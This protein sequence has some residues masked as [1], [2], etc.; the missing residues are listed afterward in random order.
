MRVITSFAL[1]VV[2]VASL[3]SCDSKFIQ[4]PESS[5]KQPSDTDMTK[6]K[7]YEQGAKIQI[8]Y[9]TDIDQIAIEIYQIPLN[10]VS[11]YTSL[12]RN[13]SENPS[14]WLAEYD[15]LGL[16]KGNE[17]SVY[18][19][20]LFKSSQGRVARSDYFNVSS[21]QADE[22]TSASMSSTAT[23]PGLATSASGQHA[24]T[25][26]AGSETDTE[27]NSS[28][29]TIST[30]STTSSTKS[31]SGLS[32]GATAGVTAG[33]II[34]GLLILGGIGLFVWRRFGKGR[35]NVKRTEE[36]QY[37]QH[38][39]YPLETKVELPSDIT[40]HPSEYATSRPGIH[41]AP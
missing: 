4:P 25:M 30:T 37:Q 21:P 32:Q 19:F 38:Q 15:F 35:K 27:H 16:A 17:D 3:A 29:S 20:T 34:G 10:G 14:Y 7:R 11:A 39:F 33:A 41:E 36:A 40:T 5:S 1:I 18:W 13:G 23:G 6:N 12:A 8:E 28:T 24:S 31:G 26:T 9:E 2:G 22:T